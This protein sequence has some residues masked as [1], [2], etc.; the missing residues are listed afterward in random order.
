MA[1]ELGMRPLVA[2]C[3]LA[4]GTLDRQA[5]ARASGGQHLDLAVTMFQEMNMRFWLDDALKERRELG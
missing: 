1:T 2:R 3:H 5:G 4:L